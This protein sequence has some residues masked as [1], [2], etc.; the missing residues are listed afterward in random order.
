MMMVSGHIGSILEYHRVLFFS[1][2]VNI[3]HFFLIISSTAKNFS[4]ILSYFF[5]DLSFNSHIKAVKKLALSKYIISGK[6]RN[7]LTQEDS[8]KLVHAFVSSGLEY[9]NA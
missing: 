4:V 7:I 8:E 3:N 5:Q 6:K 1:C 9:W 2:A